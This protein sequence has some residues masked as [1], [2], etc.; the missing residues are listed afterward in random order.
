MT[1]LELC[2]STRELAGI[3]GTGPSTTVG[4]SGE[5]LRLVNWVKKSWVDIQ[6]LHQSWNFLLADLSFTTTAGKGDYSLAEIGASDLKRLDKTSLRCQMTSM[7]YANR[8][9]ME[10]WDWIDFRDMYRFNNLVQGRPIRFSVD[11]KDKALCL[12]AIPD[13]GGY[14]ITGRYWTRPVTLAADA[15]VPAMPEQFHML[16][17]YWAL[18]KYAGYESAAEV[19]Q[20]AAENVARLRSALEIDQLPDITIG[21]SR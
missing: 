14:T 6:N 20:E 3:A 15:D 5:M 2:Q 21:S 1:F 16:I 12:A 18:S 11:P 4:Q 8:Q 19:K 10:E 17:V 7:G 9:F 13:A